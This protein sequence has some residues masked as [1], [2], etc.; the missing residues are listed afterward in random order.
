MKS[1]SVEEL[2][3]LLRRSRLLT[4]EEILSLVQRW[5]SE[6]GE[7]GDAPTS[8][9]R[10]SRWLVEGR[11]LTEYQVTTLRNGHADHFFLA[12]YK[13]LDRIGKGRQ[14]RVYKAIDRVG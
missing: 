11:F 7:P 9:D 12:G 5:R 10:F 8:L 4:P 3:R 1:N 2:C 6:T 13:L 14:M